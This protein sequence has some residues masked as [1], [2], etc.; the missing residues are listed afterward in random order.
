M[1]LKDAIDTRFGR[2]ERLRTAR[3]LIT[4]L[5]AGPAL[6]ALA[7]C[8]GTAPA[9]PSQ[10]T[11]Q[12]AATQV[13]GAASPAVATA[14]AAA[15]PAVA[16]VQAAASPAAATV[17]AAASPASA[18]AATIAGT[19]AAAVAPLVSPS[20]SP[21]PA[22]QGPLRISDASLADA[23]PW[24]SIQNDGASPVVIGGWQ[25]QVGSATASLPQEAVV[26]P[27]GTL[28]LHVG[29]GMS[30][31]DELYLGRAGEALASA[32]LPGTPVR[33]ADA[34]GRIVAEATVPRF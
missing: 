30:S 18:T 23:T 19:A 27:G 20:P 14:Q 4:W 25:L 13:V 33:L 16:T 3:S 34:N 10:P 12:A 6:L 9:A 22:A 17:Q 7:A 32:A 26:E 15:S 8:S 11:V 1:Q 28:T 29:D 24:L 2:W 5:L 31:E 21:S